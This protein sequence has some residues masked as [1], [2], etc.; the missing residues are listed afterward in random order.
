MASYVRLFGD[1]VAQTKSIELSRPIPGKFLAEFRVTEISYSLVRHQ[2]QGYSM[3]KAQDIRRRLQL[4]LTESVLEP[5]EDIP[6]FLQA[7]EWI[8][9][10]QHYSQAAESLSQREGQFSD[11]PQILLA[12]H[13]V[14]C[15]LKACLVARAQPV[16]H[17][18]DL[19]ALS[20][21]VL[22][23]GFVLHEPELVAITH[24]DSIFS[25]DLVSL[26]RFRAR[27]PTKQFQSNVQ[28]HA[29]AES[30]ARIVTSLTSQA[31]R[32]NEHANRILWSRARGDA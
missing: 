5:K 11:L 18:H 30:I 25:Q 16:P 10:A 7:S 24:L 3:G 22:D 21:V 13:S 29:S 1:S 26:A 2:N 17:T 27:Y 9:F 15:A 23:L 12:G 28:V 8:G 14:E 32:Y 31:S 6:I 4:L 20:D 19:V